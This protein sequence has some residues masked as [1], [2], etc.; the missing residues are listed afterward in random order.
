M[1]AIVVEGSPSMT[2]MSACLP[3]R[4]RSDPR[5]AAEILRAV[6][7]ADRDRFER[8]ETG[9]DQQ[10]DLPLIGEAGD[11]A[12]RAGRIGAGDQRAA[13]LHERALHPHRL[14][15]QAPRR[16]TADSASARSM[17]ALEVR[18]E[19]RRQDVEPGRH[20]T[21]GRERLEHGERRGQRDVFVDELLHQRLERLAVFVERRDRLLTARLPGQT[22]GCL[23]ATK[24]VAAK[25][26]CSRLSMPRSAAS[27]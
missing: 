9:L 7:R 18:L 27:P 5:V 20:R 22:S 13:G 2:T 16:P 1:S 11:D 25:N 8:R 10:L 6:Q 19:L 21:S 14:R 17:R 3:T 26:P 24:S 23:S 15:E 4:N 12:A